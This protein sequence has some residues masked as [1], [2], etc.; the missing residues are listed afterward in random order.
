MNLI[1]APSRAS[2]KPMRMT[3]AMSVASASPST[4]CCW[5]IAY[6]ITTNAPVG[7]PICTR[8]PP[9][10]AIRNPP[11]IAV[12]SPRSG[13][14]PLAMAKAMARGSATMPTMTPAVTSVTNWSRLY[15]RSVVTSLG[16]SVSTFPRREK[17]RGNLGRPGRYRAGPSAWSSENAPGPIAATAS[18]AMIRTR[19]YSNPPSCT[20]KPF[21]PCTLAMAT[22]MAAST[23]KPASGVS[24]PRK[25]NTPAA[26]S[27]PTASTARTEPAGAPRPGRPSGGS[28]EGHTQ[29]DV[30]NI[31]PPPAPHEPGPWHGDVA[32]GTV[33]VVHDRR[34]R[35]IASHADVVSR[36]E[37]Q[38]P[39]RPIP[40]RDRVDVVA[41]QPDASREEEAAPGS[42]VEVE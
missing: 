26:S 27:P 14:T 31:L 8:D 37:G 9:S 33:E 24:R 5:T 34:E 30:D 23:S 4:P 10:A 15:P 16:T 6:T 18:A 11:T 20:K 39:A 22:A 1:A 38:A 17:R 25:N 28:V 35:D 42:W 12:N 32:D 29:S 19:V 36:S 40:R 7:P 21:G 13:L 3:P 41:G 2:P